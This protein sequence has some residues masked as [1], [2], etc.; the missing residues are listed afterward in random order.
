MSAF[1]V[2]KEHIDYLVHAA[3]RAE[4]RTAPMPDGT[5]RFVDTEGDDIGRMLW[6]ENVTSVYYRYEPGGEAGEYFRSCGFEDDI[7]NYSCPAFPQKRFDPV[8]A[9]KAIECYEYQ[10]CEHNGWKTSA[11]KQFCD[12]LRNALI[13]ELPGI[14]Q[15][16]WE[17]TTD[18]VI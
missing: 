12:D 13:W 8:V 2:N 1:V 7:A 18:T 14:E 16:P 6:Q 4:M 9:L 10:S 15:A 3:K 11:A 17:I 5:E